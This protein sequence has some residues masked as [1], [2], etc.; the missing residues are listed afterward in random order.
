MLTVSGP[1]DDK[2]PTYSIAANWAVG[3][4]PTDVFLITGS[5][6]KTIKIQRVTISGNNSGDT[7]INVNL[8]RRSSAA[9]GGTGLPLNGNVAK[10]DSTSPTSTA[11][12][13]LYTANPTVG[14]F[15]GI[16]DTVSIFF[17]LQASGRGSL[18][19]TYDTTKHNI[20]PVILRGFNEQLC[21]NLGGVTLG[22][23]TLIN[24]AITWTEE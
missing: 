23:T 6:T 18:V 21:I 17:P 2:K 19:Y 7:N 5:A 20:Q 12:M 14:T 15:A 1:Y 4:T 8:I 13:A 22:G 10:H 3:A 24:V 11:G 16:L 9:S